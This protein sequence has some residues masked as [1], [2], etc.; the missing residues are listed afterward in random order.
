MLVGGKV[1]YK[2]G[3]MC[4]VATL[5]EQ[6]ITFT[7]GF[8]CVSQKSV[9]YLQRGTDLRLQSARTLPSGLEGHLGIQSVP[10]KGW[11]CQCL[12][13]MPSPWVGELSFFPFL[14][15]FN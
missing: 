2:H 12:A 1:L 10:V 11:I 4:H 6:E 8:I 3:F 5:V 15:P 7:K 14:F 9:K 13:L